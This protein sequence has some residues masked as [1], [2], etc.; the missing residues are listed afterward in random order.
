MAKFY[1][2]AVKNQNTLFLSLSPVSLLLRVMQ[3]SNKII[4]DIR[5]PNFG[6]QSVSLPDFFVAEDIVHYLP[7]FVATW[8]PPFSGDQFGRILG[9]MFDNEKVEQLKTMTADKS[10]SVAD[11]IFIAVLNY[12]QQ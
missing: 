9:D 8:N 3:C 5:Q 2:S 6:R 7:N 10:L 11:D 12:S 4:M 1:L